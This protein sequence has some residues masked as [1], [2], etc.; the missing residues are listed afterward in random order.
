MAAKSNATK[1]TAEIDHV[2]RFN[3]FYT[4]HIGLLDRHYLDS[5]FSLA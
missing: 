2:R 1:V 3:R 4:R 5:G